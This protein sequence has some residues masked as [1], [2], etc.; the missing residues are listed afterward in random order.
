MQD[1]INSVKYGQR[2]KISKEEY[3]EMRMNSYER[4]A[5]YPHL[6]TEALL[7]IAKHC[8]SNCSLVSHPP[9]S[10]DEAA[11][12]LLDLLVKRLY[13]TRNEDSISGL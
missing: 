7:S 12:V 8:V 3:D 6:T 2:D 11:I 1:L 10:Y 9:K 5:L 13:I 4:E